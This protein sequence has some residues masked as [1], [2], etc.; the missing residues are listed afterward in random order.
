MLP[1]HETS[2]MA[3]AERLSVRDRRNQCSTGTSFLAMATKLAS[4][5]SEASRS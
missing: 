3:P 1:L 4:R 5:A 2:A